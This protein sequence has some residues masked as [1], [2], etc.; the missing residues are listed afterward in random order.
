MSVQVNRQA[1]VLARLRLAPRPL[2]ARAA[3]GAVP[4]PSR[5]TQRTADSWQRPWPC[6]S[7]FTGRPQLLPVAAEAQRLHMTGHRWPSLMAPAHVPRCLL[8]L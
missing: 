5:L 1:R 8:P 4:S 2:R 3:Q 7:A 6:A